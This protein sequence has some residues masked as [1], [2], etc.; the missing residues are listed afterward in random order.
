MT[1]ALLGLM[2]ALS[3]PML[4]KGPNDS[5]PRMVDDYTHQ[6]SAVYNKIKL[7]HGDTPLRALDP[8]TGNTYLYA[9]GVPSLLQTWESTVKY[10]A[11][12][13]STPAYLQYPSKMVVY[14]DPHDTKIADP[15]LDLPIHQPGALTPGS[16]VTSASPKTIMT[17]TDDRE[18]ILVDINGSDPPNSLGPSGDRVLIWIDD[19]NGRILT[20]WQRCWLTTTPNTN[21]NAT[22][23]VLSTPSPARAYYK[24][25]Y[26]VYKNYTGM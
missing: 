12:T 6:L 10:V 5:W 26:D 2:V 18:W 17:G 22:S 15:G 11:A 25:F 7:Q 19:N 16:P 13:G 8:N 24:S 21:P 23:C 3:I 9:D 20:A 1:L 14:V 4:L